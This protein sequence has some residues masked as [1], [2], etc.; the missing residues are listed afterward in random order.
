MYKSLSSLVPNAEVLLNLEI[1]ALGILLL[2]HLKS[3]EGQPGNS[4]FQNGLI[5]QSNFV[6][7]LEQTSYDQK[8][9]YGDKQ[10]QVIQALME[11]WARLEKKAF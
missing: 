11:A 10:A 9:E 6:R 1:E 5:S 2:T 3:Y 7:A 8:P 4:V